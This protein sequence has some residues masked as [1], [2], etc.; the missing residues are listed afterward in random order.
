MK[1]LSILLFLYGAAVATLTVALFKRKKVAVVDGNALPGVSI[2]IPFRNEED[3]LPALLESLWK[4]SYKG[5]M[6]VIL[7]NDNSEDDW[8]RIIDKQCQHSGHIPIK[9]IDLHLSHSPL[10]SKQQALDL[11][12]ENSICPLIAFTDA[13]MILAPN[14]VESLVASHLSMGSDLVFGHTA[15]IDKRSKLLDFFEAYQLQFLFAFAY[16]ISKLNLT[17]G[18]CMG[19][20]I[21]VTKKS[22]LECGGQRGIG[23]SIV[24]DRALLGLM[25]K[26]GFKTAAAEPFFVT[27][28][29]HPSRSKKQFFNQMMRWAAGGL[30]PGGG[31]FVAGLLLFAQNTLFLLTLIIGLISIIPVVS[32]PVSISSMPTI[33]VIQSIVNFLLTWVF[34]AL[35]FKK[36]RSPA[37]KLFYPVYYFFMMKETLIFG[38]LMIF[39]PKIHW[40]GR[41]I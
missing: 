40:K 13:D 27:A 21:L 10:T 38:F 26:K 41:G 11:G 14:W 8:A 28:Q 4:Q 3:N 12:V 15:I 24:E 1:I 9:I 32:L 31:L 36:T 19:N 30:R 39:R 2:V 35:A 18:S 37:S 7:I 33:I 23:R 17:T 34:L 25:R 16:A 22:Y 20:N 5:M 6:E 29:T